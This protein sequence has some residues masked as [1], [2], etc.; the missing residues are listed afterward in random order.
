[1]RTGKPAF[2]GLD[3]RAVPTLGEFIT[4]DYAK[5]IRDVHKNPKQTLAGLKNAFSSL[6]HKALTDDITADL[7][8]WKSKRLQTGASPASIR[9]NLATLSGV[10]RRASKIKRREIGPIQNPVADVERPILDNDVAPR[11]LSEDDEQKLMAA[12]QGRDEESREARMRSN[13]I[14]EKRGQKPLRELPYFADHL[15]PMVI[16]SINTGCRRGELFALTWDHVDLDG[17]AVTFA[18]ATTKSSKTRIVPLNADALLVLQRWQEQTGNKQGLVFPGQAGG[19]ITTIK[20][21]WLKLIR[22]AGIS[23]TWHGLRHTFGTRL[24]ERGAGLATIC[25]LMGHSDIRITQRYTKPG[26]PAKRA[27]VDLLSSAP[28]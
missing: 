13:A 26:D 19:E 11:A 1:M 16:F 14:R 3:S 17:R 2:H 18:G 28:T 12:L 24:A 15:T 22:K 8:T 6:Y 23:C 4:G 21:A 10:Y 5:Q 27:A 20:T 25:E 7:E 9:R